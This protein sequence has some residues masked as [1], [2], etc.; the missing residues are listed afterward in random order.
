MKEGRKK[1]RKEEKER[2]K[3][4]HGKNILEFYLL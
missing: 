3:E 1:G 4:R 2:K